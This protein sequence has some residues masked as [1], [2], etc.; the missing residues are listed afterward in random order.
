MCHGLDVI[1]TQYPQHYRRVLLYAPQFWYACTQTL[2]KKE[3]DPFLRRVKS[4]LSTHK[5]TVEMICFPLCNGQHWFTVCISLEDEEVRIAEGYGYKPPPGFCDQI[6]TILGTYFDVP[7]K[8]W[9]Q[10]L[11]RMR[12]PTQPKENYWD[13]GPIAL[14]VIES[15]YSGATQ[16]H[17]S[18]DRWESYR[19]NWIRRCVQLHQRKLPILSSGDAS[20]TTNFSNASTSHPPAGDSMNSS[21][22]KDKPTDPSNNSDHSNDSDDE[23]SDS[24][25]N[26][27]SSTADLTNDDDFDAYGDVNIAELDRRLLELQQTASTLRHRINNPDLHSSKIKSKK[28]SIPYSMTPI[29]ARKCD[30]CG[31]PFLNDV[32]ILHNPICTWECAYRYANEAV[33][34]PTGWLCILYSR[35][36]NPDGIP[37]FPGNR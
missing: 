21:D 36:L 19:I 30:F 26:S 14:A 10:R 32:K 25:S 5:D 6:L 15:V 37:L 4:D 7:T 2:R 35:E 18:T 9:K 27:G 23:T 29:T 31:P 13:C 28:S 34:K 12:C 8:N 3:L 24:S 17:W 20:S 1:K 33:I 22:S 11:C 16:I